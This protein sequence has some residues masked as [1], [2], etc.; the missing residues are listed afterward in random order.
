MAQAAVPTEILIQLNTVLTSLLSHDNNQRAAA[1]AQL[2]EQWVTS[3]PDLLLLGL[4]QFV[5]NNTEA[6]LRSYC[7]VLLRRLAYRQITIDSREESLWNIV[8][9]NTQQGVKEL[10]LFALAN[11]TDQATAKTGLGCSFHSMIKSFSLTKGES[12]IHRLELPWL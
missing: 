4:A 1:E 2:N 5:A 6:H 12:E 10:L 3:Q 8:N 11:E 9:E 7:S